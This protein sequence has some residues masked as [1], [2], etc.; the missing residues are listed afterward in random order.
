[1]SVLVSDW[2]R[3]SGRVHVRPG[4]RAPHAAREHWCNHKAATSDPDSGGPMT[5]SAFR[6]V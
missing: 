4:A 5:L 1:M 3:W 6:K 2:A